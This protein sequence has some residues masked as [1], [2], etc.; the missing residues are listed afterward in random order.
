MDK[1]TVYEADVY[2]LEHGKVEATVLSL[3]DNRKFDEARKEIIKYEKSELGSP[4]MTKG[5]W[6]RLHR[7]EGGK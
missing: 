5:L 3:L 6:R 1:N 2:R 7:V 4:G